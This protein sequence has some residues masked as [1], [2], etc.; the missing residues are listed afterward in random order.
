DQCVCNGG[1]GRF[2]PTAKR[3][4]QR[5]WPTLGPSRADD[6]DALGGLLLWHWS[7]AAI[8]PGSGAAPCLPLVLLARSGRQGPAPFDILGEPAPPPPRG[9][10][11]SPWFLSA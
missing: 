9:G 6:P 8:V 4:L 3:F 1:S 10:D 11:P 2:A 5:H 7:R